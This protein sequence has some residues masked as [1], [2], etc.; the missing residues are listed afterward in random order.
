M[1][2]LPSDKLFPGMIVA[3]PVVTKR[4]QVIFK[5]GTVLTAQLIGRLSF[6]NVD[7][8]TVE[9]P[10][11]EEEPEPAPAP[12]PASNAAPANISYNQ[13]LK[14]SPEFKQFQ[15]DFAKNIEWMKDN[16]DAIMN[17]AGNECCE[18]MI[19]GAESLFK[20]R[21]SIELFDMIHNMRGLDD[22]VY[23]HSL[24]VALIARAIGKWCKMGRAELDTLTVAGLLHD[25][26]K[27]QIPEEVLNKPGKYT[28]EEWALVKSHPML[29]YKVLK[30]RDFDKSITLAAL[31]HHERADG[32]GYPRGLVDD[33][34]DDVASVIA[35]ADVYDAM[36]AFRSYR[37]PLCAFQVIAQFEKEGL[38]K[39]NTKYILTFLEHVASTYQNSRVVL[40]NAKA[41]R[42]VY[43]NK[44]KLSRPVIELDD[45]S[46]V[47]L[48][49]SDYS[50]LTITKIV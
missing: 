16:F 33:E 10:K 6:Y 47:D 37:D 9:D 41:G 8:V 34:I 17:G 45:K 46:I 15:L 21:T 30:G 20:S 40:S 12:A 22:S 42:V 38:S 18:M 43:I 7:E 44:S 29:G 39:Y 24:N 2:K 36:T 5:V 25:I 13:R 32:S 3:E 14:A 27:T 28:D 49:N 23:A 26:G 19:E 1:Q 50:D 48:S 4:G 11:T 35:I 31:Q